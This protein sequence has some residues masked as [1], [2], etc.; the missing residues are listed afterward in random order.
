ME[1]FSHRQILEHRTIQFSIHF[2]SSLHPLGSS[3]QNNNSSVAKS[4][5]PQVWLQKLS[6]DIFCDNCYLLATQFAN[7]QLTFHNSTS[8]WGS[9]NCTSLVLVWSERGWKPNGLVFECHLNTGQPN[10]LNTRLMK[11]IL[12]SYVMVHLVVLLWLGV[13]I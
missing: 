1:C 5:V 6:S 2:T 4:K 7:F 12:F 11:A 13:W 10:H 8:Q 3:I 9:E